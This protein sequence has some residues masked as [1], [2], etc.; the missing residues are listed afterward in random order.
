MSST[1]AVVSD[2]EIGCLSPSVLGSAGVQSTSMAIAGI[3][4]FVGLEF[5]ILV[6]PKVA[7]AAAEGDVSRVAS[8]SNAAAAA[9]H[10]IQLPWR[11]PEPLFYVFE[12]PRTV[13]R[14]PWAIDCSATEG[15]DEFAAIPLSVSLSS[16][17]WA[18]IP[19]LR[20]SCFIEASE[21]PRASVSAVV[22]GQSVE[23]EF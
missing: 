11:G 9:S 19:F 22:V 4:S 18:D 12:S 16:V 23:C 5:S 15:A 7:S 20:L 1:A 8:V 17:Q 2:T 14:H 10:A 13:D 21:M 6:R 3:T